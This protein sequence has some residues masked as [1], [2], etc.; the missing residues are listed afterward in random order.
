[1]NFFK[2]S[3]EKREITLKLTLREIGIR[4]NFQDGTYMY[5]SFET[6]TDAEKAEAI[7]KSED[8]AK[9]IESALDRA[10]LEGKQLV[11]L[12]KFGLIYVKDFKSATFFDTPKK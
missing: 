11:L 5:W 12:P 3:P 2:K 6:E 4:A 7:E 8:L 9:Q 10:I 1:V